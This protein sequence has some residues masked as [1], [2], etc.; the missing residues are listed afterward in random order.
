MPLSAT[1]A[2]PRQQSSRPRQGRDRLRE[3]VTTLD[4]SSLTTLPRALRCLALKVAT[5]VAREIPADREAGAGGG[6]A[7][8]VVCPREVVDALQRRKAP[9]SAVGTE[10]IV[11]VERRS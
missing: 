2:V 4:A 7:D 10:A 1:T 11:E 9:K 3:G 5:P 8:L 6:R